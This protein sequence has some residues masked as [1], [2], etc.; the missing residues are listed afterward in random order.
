WVTPQLIC[1]VSFSEWTQEGQMRQPIFMGLREDKK[2]KEVTKEVATGLPQLTHL[3]KV[4]WPKEEYTKGDLLEYY[5]GI[6]P[7]ILPY[8][9]LRPVSLYR[10]PNGIEEKGFFQKNI[11][12]HAPSW[13]S[14][15]PIQH[16]K[17]IIKYLTIPDKNSL[18]YAVNLGSIDLHPFNSHAPTLQNP[19]YLVIDLDPFEI[20]FSKVIDTAIF[21]HELL[22]SHAIPSYCKT[23]GATGLHLYLP[24][25]AQYPYEIVNLFAQL[26]A[27]LIQGQ[28]PKVTSVERTPANRRRKVY[29]DYLQN[30]FGKTMAAPYCVRPQPGAPVSTPLDWKEVKEGLDPL[31]F[32]IK[33]V[34][35]RVR[36]KGD[37]FRGVLGKGIDLMRC[38]KKLGG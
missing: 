27:E 38:L 31:D 29:L 7:F 14:T 32:T 3:D 15:I 17:E 8:L 28:L 11:D 13:I 1:E 34:P 37:L 9:K 24:L 33:N 25:K 10:L 18:L 26:L 30:S 22:E 36:K 35:E 4:Y 19:D 23:S 6:A 20:S 12:R 5:D 2:P 16:G 21:I